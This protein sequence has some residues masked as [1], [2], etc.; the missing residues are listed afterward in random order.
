MKNSLSLLLNPTRNEILN[1]VQA[2]VSDQKWPFIRSR[3]LRSLGEKG[4]EG[5]LLGLLIELNKLE[6]IRGQ[7]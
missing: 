2:A 1:I 6:V 7:K 5:R 3:I 4:L